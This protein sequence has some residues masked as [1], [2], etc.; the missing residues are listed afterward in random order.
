MTSTNSAWKAADS[1]LQ[2]QPAES[3]GGRGRSGKG[4]EK[5]SSS[6]ATLLYRVREKAQRA[7][8]YSGSQRMKNRRIN[9]RPATASASQALLCEGLS[10]LLQ[11]FANC[12]STRKILTGGFHT[13]MHAYTLSVTIPRHEVL[14]FKNKPPLQATRTLPFRYMLNSPLD[15]NTKTYSVTQTR[16]DL[17]ISWKRK[18]ID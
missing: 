18:K 3:G 10:G 4:D 11:Q 7:C 2:G 5:T 14:P 17:T 8:R 16:S 9:R 1:R 6:F 13:H 12:L 15:C